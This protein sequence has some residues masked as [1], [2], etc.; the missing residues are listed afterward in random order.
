MHP[1]S[2]G[3]VDPVTIKEAVFNILS[4]MKPQAAAKRLNDAIIAGEAGLWQN[5]KEIDSVNLPGFFDRHL[6]IGRNG[7]LDCE[8]V[9]DS[10]GQ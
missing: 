9:H 4:A 10:G 5:D 8:D 6:R 3:P 1:D 7:W 2:T